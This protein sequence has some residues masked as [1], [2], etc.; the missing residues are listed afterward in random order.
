MFIEK[1]DVEAKMNFFF[2]DVINRELAFL[3]FYSQHSFSA[4]LNRLKKNNLLYCFNF[5]SYRNIYIFMSKLTDNALLRTLTVAIS[6]LSS[7]QDL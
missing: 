1:H 7:P 3:Q 5:S 4:I 6:D 2:T